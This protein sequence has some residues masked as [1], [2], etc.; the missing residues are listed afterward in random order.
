MNLVAK[1]PYFAWTLTVLFGDNSDIF[2]E[3]IDEKNKSYL[4]DGQYLPLK[5]YKEEIFV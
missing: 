1:T 5:I 3:T 4:L 2:I